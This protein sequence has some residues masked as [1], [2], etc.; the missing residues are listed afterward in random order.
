MPD[1]IKSFHVLFT[2]IAAGILFG[3]GFSLAQLVVGWPASR[4]AAGAAIICV[5]LVLVA[6][7]IP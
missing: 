4:V 5:L 7:L 1:A 3:L 2:L 6:W